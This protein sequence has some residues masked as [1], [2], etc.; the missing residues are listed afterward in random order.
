MPAVGL[1]EKLERIKRGE[2]IGKD[3]KIHKIPYHAKKMLILHL[4]ETIDPE[5]I[6]IDNN[7]T[8][9]LDSSSINPSSPDFSDILKYDPN[10]SQKLQA[11]HSETTKNINTQS[12]N[13]YK[14]IQQDVDKKSNKNLIPSNGNLQQQ[15]TED[16]FNNISQGSDKNSANPL[17]FM[18]G[19]ANKPEIPKSAQG[20]LFN[21]ALAQDPGNKTVFADP[22]TGLTNGTPSMSNQ[23]ILTNEQIDTLVNDQSMQNSMEGCAN[24]SKGAGA[25][26]LSSESLTTDLETLQKEGPE[27]LKDIGSLQSN[28]PADMAGILADKKKCERFIQVIEIILSLPNT[29][30]LM[31]KKIIKRI[32]KQ[33][34]KVIDSLKKKGLDFWTEVIGAELMAIFG[35]IFK[36]CILGAIK[37]FWRI[38]EKTAEMIWS[39]LKLFWKFLK[40]TGKKMLENICSIFN[41]SQL[42]PMVLSNFQWGTRINSK[43]IKVLKVLRQLCR[44]LSEIK[45]LLDKCLSD[46]QKAIKEFM[47]AM[48]STCKD[49]LDEM[50]N[51]EVILNGI[52][53]F[54]SE[55]V[56][57][58][59]NNVTSAANG[60]QPETT[61]ASSSGDPLLNPSLPSSVSNSPVPAAS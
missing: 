45:S 48:A 15:N 19:L 38:A 11:Q 5:L 59:S 23:G 14:N 47:N 21:N 37:Q 30:S 41:D 53:N 16:T 8:K 13:T 20:D 55:Q 3:G 51:K 40:I 57:E 34:R 32:K 22:V 26:S 43:I 35:S 58:L 27:V 10:N 49:A 60:P 17:G 36:T 44:L 24:L 1:Q 56:N 4:Q 31:F 12:N 33:I 2:A 25:E 18:R 29:I 54:T 6:E 46:L 52:I 39:N 9:T 28:N 50:V 61:K 42:A 7:F